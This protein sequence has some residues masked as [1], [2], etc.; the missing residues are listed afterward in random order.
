MRIIRAKRRQAIRIC[1]RGKKKMIQKLLEETEK[2][3]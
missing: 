2:Y 1:R 3:N